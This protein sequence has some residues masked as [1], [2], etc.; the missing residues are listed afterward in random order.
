MS[1]ITNNLTFKYI[2]NSRLKELHHK[3]STL[4][5]PFYLRFNKFL[6]PISKTPIIQEKIA[7]WVLEILN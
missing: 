1:S 2:F 6:G 5:F 3:K 4:L 7:F